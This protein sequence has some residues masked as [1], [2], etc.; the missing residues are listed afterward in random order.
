MREIFSWLLGRR[1]RA[2]LALWLLSQPAVSV[3]YVPE[4]CSASPCQILAGDR[5]DIALDHES[6]SPSYRLVTGVQPIKGMTF[7]ERSNRLLWTPSSDQVGSYEITF[8]ELDE[9]E[10]WVSSAAVVQ[11]A[12][13]DNT[14][15]DW[16]SVV[17]VAPEEFVVSTPANMTGTPDN[18]YD[19]DSFGARYCKDSEGN[20]RELHQTVFFRGGLHTTASGD[21][22]S[23]IFCGGLSLDQP[24]TMKPWGNERPVLSPKGSHAI[25]IRGDF[26]TLDKEQQRCTGK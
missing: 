7:L 1:C 16:E 11:I 23:D 18:P 8:E 13:G 25:K 26:V 5:V 22:P 14:Q 12:V 24:F 9:N 4:V 2:A 20:P 6:D 21:N 17:F 19:F 10:Q 15:I 3:A